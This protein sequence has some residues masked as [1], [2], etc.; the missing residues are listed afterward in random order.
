M[1]L[2]TPRASK[3][4][5]TRLLL[6]TR[7]TLGVWLIDILGKGSAL[8]EGFKAGV[9]AYAGE[10]QADV[11]DEIVNSLMPEELPEFEMPYTAEQ[12]APLPSDDEAVEGEDEAADGRDQIIDIEEA[13]VA[14]DVIPEKDAEEVVGTDIA[15]EGNVE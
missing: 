11:N 13:Q 1:L 5:W 3:R 9:T 15:G 4:E 7:E 12:T 6:C 14:D 2:P 10:F 8:P